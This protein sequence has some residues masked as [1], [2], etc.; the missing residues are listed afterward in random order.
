MD[1]S[2]FTLYDSWNK[3][4]QQKQ[5]ALCHFAEERIISLNTHSHCYSDLNAAVQILYHL[6]YHRGWSVIIILEGWTLSEGEKKRVGMKLL[7][8]YIRNNNSRKPFEILHISVQTKPVFN[9]FNNK[10][11]YSYF[12]AFLLSFYMKYLKVGHQLCFQG[13]SLTDIQSYY[14][15][16]SDSQ[17]HTLKEISRPWVRT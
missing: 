17:T 7:I 10:I 14:H 1:K 11:S 5:R 6:N 9:N 4:F 16:V 3:P 12:I 13:S 15:T 2:S 8:Y